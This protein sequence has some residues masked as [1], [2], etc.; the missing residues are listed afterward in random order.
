MGL[1]LLERA[2]ALGRGKDAMHA[3]RSSA[4]P[5]S[6]W[7]ASGAG[8]MGELF[9]VHGGH[10]A[11]PSLL[12]PFQRDCKKAGLTACHWLPTSPPNRTASH[13]AAADRPAA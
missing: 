2:G 3:G 7:P 12:P 9:K 4:R 5:S 13:A 1:G 8:K 11:R 10:Q 6:G